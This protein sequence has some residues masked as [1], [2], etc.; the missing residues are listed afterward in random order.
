LL[1]HTSI[2]NRFA[3]C[4]FL[5]ENVYNNDNSALKLT[6]DD[7]EN[8]WHSLQSLGMQFDDYTCDSAL[9]ISGVHSI[10]QVLDQQ[11]TRPGGEGGGQKL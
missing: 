7:E 11:L 9:E 3:K 1:S 5:V 10:N 6:E 2:K 8:G 4:G